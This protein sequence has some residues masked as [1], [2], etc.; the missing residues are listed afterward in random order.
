MALAALLIGSLVAVST[1][2]LASVIGTRDVIAALSSSR[3]RGV[4]KHLEKVPLWRPIVSGYGS[5]HERIGLPEIPQRALPG[6]A[7]A[8]LV[9]VIVAGLLI[10]RSAAGAVMGFVVVVTLLALRGRGE[11]AIQLRRMREAL[12]DLTRSLGMSI[13]AGAPLE[14]ALGEIAHRAPGRLASG[15]ERASIEMSYGVMQHEALGRL[16]SDHPELDLELLAVSLEVSKETGSPLDGILRHVARILSTKLELEGTLQVK[17]A[18]SRLSAMIVGALPIVMF[19]ILMLLS[20]DYRTGV[21]TGRGV[22]ALMAALALETLA[23]LMMART[24]EVAS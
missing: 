22:M 12:P 1:A 6:E 21:A 14:R 9:L 7:V 3:V 8:F 5:L 17:T 23:L 19:G 11:E 13:G 15:L 24:M 4:L 18:Q 2:L 10:T 20:E 16:V